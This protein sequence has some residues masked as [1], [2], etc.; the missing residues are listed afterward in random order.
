MCSLVFVLVCGSSGLRASHQQCPLKTSSPRG[1]CRWRCRG[2]RL[3]TTH[4]QHMYCGCVGHT[5][6]HRDAAL[7]L[8]GAGL[9][10][11][12]FEPHQT[13]VSS[14]NSTTHTHLFGYARQHP[15]AAVGT[16]AAQ[17]GKSETRLRLAA[18]SAASTATPTAG[19]CL[20]SGRQAPR[21]AS[22]QLRG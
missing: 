1:R 16:S 5:F 13:C 21:A 4:A 2:R 14:Q 18:S 3:G 10:V 17:L 7:V 8:V 11:R 15:P 19:R 6:I 22:V 9:G 20:Q 12:V